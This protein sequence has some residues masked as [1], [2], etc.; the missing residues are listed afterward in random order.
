MPCC[1]VNALNLVAHRLSFHDCRFDHHAHVHLAP[2]TSGS[3]D[4]RIGSDITTE[5]SSYEARGFTCH[6]QTRPQFRRHHVLIPVSALLLQ[7][8]DELIGDLSE[9]IN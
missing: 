3:H 5:T 1:F 6:L 8:A 2:V 4:S 9:L 7:G